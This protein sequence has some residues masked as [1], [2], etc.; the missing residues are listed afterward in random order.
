MHTAVWMYCQINERRF[1]TTKTVF[2]WWDSRAVW[3]WFLLKNPQ[4]GH[5]L[6]TWR[7]TTMQGWPGISIVSWFLLTSTSLHSSRNDDKKS[8]KK[9]AS[10]DVYSAH[11][12][13]ISCFFGS[14]QREFSWTHISAK[15]T[16]THVCFSALTFAGSLG[17]SLNTRPSGLLFKQ[18]PRDPAN[19]N[20]WKTCLIPILDIFPGNGPWADAVCYSLAVLYR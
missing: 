20:A 10:I 19:V 2:K 15:I 5:R 11:K 7:Q 6:F 3:T 17:R 1:Q 9:K 14:F 12:A 8:K 4:D 16:I 13:T 18:F